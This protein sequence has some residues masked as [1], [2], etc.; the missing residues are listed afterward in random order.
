MHSNA[1]TVRLTQLS[2]LAAIEVL[3]SFTPLGFIPLPAI[4]ITTLHIPVIIGAIILGPKDGGILGFVMGV[5]SLLRA[6]FA[7]SGVTAILISPFTSGAPVLSIIMVF[8]PRI[9]I[10]VAAGYAYIALKKR[11]TA[12][13]LSVGIAAAAG[14]LTNSVL[15]LGMMSIFF[16]S[17]PLINVL[18]IIVG[19]NCISEIIAA[20]VISIGVCLPLLK[21]MKKKVIA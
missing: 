11:H 8:V 17:F 19:V 1:S 14:T 21:Y 10:G 16:S 12:T 15:F 20:I 18:S 4:S 13:A 2:L 9:L 3:L 7:P 5:C 6:T